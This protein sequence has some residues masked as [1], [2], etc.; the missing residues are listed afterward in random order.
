MYEMPAMPLVYDVLTTPK[1]VRGLPS[2]TRSACISPRMDSHAPL[3]LPPV[4]TGALVVYVAC[5]SALYAAIGWILM[6]LARNAS[7]LEVAMLPVRP[8]RLCFTG[9]KRR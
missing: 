9:T 6:V 8:L 2:A 5:T 7:L 3:L 1:Y 4:S